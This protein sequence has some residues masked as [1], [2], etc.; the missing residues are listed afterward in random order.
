MPH[1]LL[2]LLSLAATL[3][4][5]GPGCRENHNPGDPQQEQIS[6]NTKTPAVTV[7][8][9]RPSPT[10]DSPTLRVVCWNL[11]WFP[12]GKMSSSAAEKRE[13]TA[14][15]TAALQSLN[16]DVL[17]LQEVQPG[18]ELESLLTNLDPTFKLHVRSS[19]SGRQQL[20]IAS[21]LPAESAWAA[22]WVKDGA[23]DP[24]RGYAYA[25]LRLPEPDGRLMMV[26]TL[27]LK[28]NAGARTLE[29]AAANREK[30]Q[31]A[32]RQLLAHIKDQRV[33]TQGVE[34][35]PI[36]IAGDL[37]TDPDADQ[38]A[39]EQTIP[40]LVEGGFTWLFQGMNRAQRITW[41]SDGRYPDAHFDHAFARNL[42][43]TTLTVPTTFEHCSDH[44]PVVID[45]QLLP[46]MP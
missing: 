1:P 46:G 38:F 34:N 18:P 12:G 2:R 40:L 9:A 24:P 19:F 44:Q 43:P 42:E 14:K 5:A 26:Y 35:A 10:T 32:I 30:R 13:H 22:S 36:L 8:P 33:T 15:V 16:P 27:H 41:P 6:E 39:G 20:C 23:D 31:D 7:A 11:K 29:E 45:L 4:V 28:S 17:L 25:A 37:N 21:R 3:L